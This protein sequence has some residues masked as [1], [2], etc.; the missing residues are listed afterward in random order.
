VPDK[1]IGPSSPSAI[2]VSEI[3]KIMIESTSFAMLSPLR[4]DLTSL[5]QSN[6]TALAT[7]GKAEGRR[8]N[9]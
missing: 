7:E 9:G 6:E 5:L 4:L 8:N 3:L 1:T 2:D